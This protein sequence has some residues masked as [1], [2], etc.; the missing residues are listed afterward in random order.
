VGTCRVSDWSA[1][2]GGGMPSA[3]RARRVGPAS[4]GEWG[5]PNATTGSSTRPP[6]SPAEPATG[7]PTSRVR[8]YDPCPQRTS[9]GAEILRVGSV[10]P[11]MAQQPTILPSCWEN[12][13]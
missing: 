3:V 11:E 9:A 12:A 8:S 10:Q 6:A 4:H 1:G 7:L 5:V 13:C 2:F